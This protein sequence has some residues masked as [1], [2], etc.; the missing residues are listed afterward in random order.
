MAYSSASGILVCRFIRWEGSAVP[1]KLN[2]L[3][4]GVSTAMA[5]LTIAAAPIAA[6]QPSETCTVLTTSSTRCESP[7]NAEVNDSLT[8]ANTLP[9]WSSFGEQSGG[10]FGG[11]LGGGSR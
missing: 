10:P 9:Q 8:R 1:T 3:A 7:G 5:A 4:T 11:T 6:A 2:Y